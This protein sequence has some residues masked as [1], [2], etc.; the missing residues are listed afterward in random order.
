MTAFKWQYRKN[1]DYSLEMEV[2][3]IPIVFKWQY[4]RY[5]PPSNGNTV[6]HL[7]YCLQMSV[8]SMPIVFIKWQYHRYVPPSNGNTVRHLDYCLQMA[9]PYGIYCVQMLPS[10]R[11]V[12]NVAAK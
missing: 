10:I 1:L 5:V 11:D 4:H 12:S 7:H 8:P 3:S 6:R 2:P 9:I